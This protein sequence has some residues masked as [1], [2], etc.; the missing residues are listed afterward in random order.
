[1]SQDRTVWPLGSY[2]EDEM[3]ARGWT[4]ADVAARMGPGRDYGTDYLCVEMLLAVHDR[5]L[6]LDDDTAI[7]L[8]NAFGVSPQYFTYLHEAWRR[9]G[10]DAAND[11]R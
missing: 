11:G 2:L 4:V 5:N 10:L 8:G 3:N 7:G 1:M 6:L 9:H